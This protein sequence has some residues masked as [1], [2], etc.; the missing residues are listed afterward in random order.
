MVHWCGG[1]SLP[2]SYILSLLFL[3]SKPPR[4]ALAQ[5]LKKEPTEPNILDYLTA[6]HGHRTKQ[7]STG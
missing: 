6:S 1:E 5:G 2:V 7:E 3:K 4:F